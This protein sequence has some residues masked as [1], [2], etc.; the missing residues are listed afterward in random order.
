MTAVNVASGCDCDPDCHLCPTPKSCWLCCNFGSEG[1][2]TVQTC[3]QYL[4][5]N[6]ILFAMLTKT[7]QNANTNKKG[8]I[9]Q[10]HVDI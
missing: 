9:T 3:T 4:F 8:D 10:H 1:K 7:E 2:S 6:C 5:L